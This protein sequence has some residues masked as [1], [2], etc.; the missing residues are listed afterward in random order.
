MVW[1]SGMAGAL[2]LRSSLGCYGILSGSQLLRRIATAGLGTAGV[3]VRAGVDCVVRDD[4]GVGV[5]DLAAWR[6]GCGTRCAERVRVAAGAQWVVELAVLCVAHGGMGVRRYR[7]AV[8][9]AGGDN[10]D[11]RS[12]QPWCCVAAGSLSAVGQLCGGAEL[13]GMAAQSSAAWVSGLRSTRHAWVA[14]LR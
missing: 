7:G 11:V 3:V 14:R 1:T 13:C 6:V 5:V 2:L 12:A 9:G 10:R 4:G 8:V